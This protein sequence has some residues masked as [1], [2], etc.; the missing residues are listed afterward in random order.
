MREIVV[1]HADAVTATELPRSTSEAD[2]ASPMSDR[3]SYESKESSKVS[4]RVLGSDGRESDGDEAWNSTAI[5]HF[6]LKFDAFRNDT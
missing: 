2:H 3:D 4:G 1:R 5:N 6:P